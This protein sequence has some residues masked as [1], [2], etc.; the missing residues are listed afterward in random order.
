MRTSFVVSAFQAAN[1]KTSCFYPQL[2][3]SGFTRLVASGA[4]DEPR[5]VLD[6][7]FDFGLL[8]LLVTS[9]FLP[10][11]SFPSYRGSH[12]DLGKLDEDFLWRHGRYRRVLLMG[13]RALRLRG[14]RGVNPTRSGVSGIIQKPLNP[15]NNAGHPITSIPYEADLGSAFRKTSPVRGLAD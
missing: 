7:S 15:A 4:R 10:P 2:H 3:P 13:G 11:A 1:L 14:G 6:A 9:Y 8:L 5:A 12:N